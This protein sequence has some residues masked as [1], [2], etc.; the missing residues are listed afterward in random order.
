MYSPVKIEYLS[1]RGVCN[2]ALGH[3][4]ST[5]ITVDGLLYAWGSNAKG[6]LGIGTLAKEFRKVG[7]PRL[8]DHILGYPAT[9]IS[10]TRSNTSFIIAEA[11]PEF[12]TMVF[13]LWKKN[14]LIDERMLGERANYKF[15]LFYRQFLK[16]KLVEK[17]QE[18]RKYVKSVG[19]LG[20]TMEGRRCK[21][22]SG[23]YAFW[24]AYNTSKILSNE[25]K[26]IT[27][28]KPSHR[29]APSPAVT[30]FKRPPQFSNR[31]SVTNNNTPFDIRNVVNVASAQGTM[32]D[33]GT[34]IELLNA[35]GLNSISEN[36][37]EKDKERPI[38]YESMNYKAG[39][40]HSVSL[41]TAGLF[42]PYDLV[43][44]S[45]LLAPLPDRLF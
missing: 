9:F 12:N 45:M 42:Y 41:M 22:D 36:T 29:S 31:K 3:E 10:A 8:L 25:S 2:M 24:N 43:P 28:T 16:R 20:S 32:P 18:E 1:G 14:M 35:N 37:E 33:L 21:A 27:F 11:H 19:R 38:Y 30:L 26:V 4:H 17:V 34:E 7:L 13:N 40:K 23:Y 5:A 15:T 44:N 39:Y 6:Q